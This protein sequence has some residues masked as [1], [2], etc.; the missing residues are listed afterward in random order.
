[1]KSIGKSE[2]LGLSENLAMSEATTPACLVSL[3]SQKAGEDVLERLQRAPHIQRLLFQMATVDLLR[4]AKRHA[5]YRELSKI[6]GRQITV[7][8]RY[9]KGHVLPNL[10]RSVEIWRELAPLYGLKSALMELDVKPGGIV[11]TSSVLGDPSVLRMVA[12]DCVT[13]YAGYRVTKVLAAT[14]NS[15]PLATMV[16]SVLMTPMVIAKEYMDIGVDRFLESIRGI[17]GERFD[18]LYIPKGSIAKRDSVLIVEDIVRTGKTVNALVELVDR[19]K[20]E[21]AGVYCL[22][23][24]KQGLEKLRERGLKVEAVVEVA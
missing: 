1:M 24:F 23:A 4:V 21:V 12:A 10:K 20:A 17:A 9:V 8:S 5:T 19:A 3:V 15:T 13:R 11:D 18:T 22:V 7:I 2:Y 14:C 6:L 16:S